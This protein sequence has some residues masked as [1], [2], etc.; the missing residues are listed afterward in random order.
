MR[1]TGLLSTLVVSGLLLACVP[2]PAPGASAAYPEPNRPIRM[3][4]PFP[5]GGNT[6]IVARAIADKLREYLGTTVVID[7]RGGAGGAIGS[8]L[9]AKAP[10]DGYTILM[11]SASHV[12][13][14][15][16]VKK[17]PYDTVKEFAGISLVAD[18]PTVLVV[19]PSLPARTLQELI[20]V[21]KERPGKLHFGSSGIGTVGHLSGELLNSVAQIK[22]VHVPFKGNA[23]AMTDLLGGHLDMMFSSMP[24]AMP[25]IQS[26]KLRA[27][28]VTSAARSTAAPS[29]P[30][31]AESGLPGFLVST[32]FGLFAPAATPRPIINKL[33]AEVVKALQVPEVRERLASQGAEP[34]GSTPEEY[35]AFVRSEIAKWGKVVK[36]AGITPE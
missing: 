3:I 13:N 31:M 22:A 30:T 7:N 20:A 34:V 36:E 16:M 18:V 10:A 4:V 12:I 14:P 21:A 28:A 26:A 17:L 2:A 9:V 27:I 5:P 24:S 32:G 25:H 35:D 1:K 15:S 33:H 11:V 8:E 23:P 19:H 6:D 29:I